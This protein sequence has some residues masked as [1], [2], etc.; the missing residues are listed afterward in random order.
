MPLATSERNISDPVNKMKRIPHNYEM[1]PDKRRLSLAFP[2]LLLSVVLMICG[3]AEIAAQ[4]D[5]G[6]AV[7][8]P[9]NGIDCGTNTSPCVYCSWSP[10]TVNLDTGTSITATASGG[11]LWETYHYA[12]GTGGYNTLTLHEYITMGRIPECPDQQSFANQIT[13]TFSQPVTKVHV[14]VGGEPSFTATDNQGNQV[15]ANLSG[16]TVDLY[17]PNSG[18]S[19][20][21]IVA[22]ITPG[23][24]WSWWIR[25]ASFTPPVVCNCPA[26]PPR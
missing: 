22:N 3:Y 23:N 5:C 14:L 21:T 7:S 1:K 12:T 8:L 4:T 15:T 25:G 16:E 26:I 9:A 24:G 20:V 11:F 13:I 18:I 17:L 2:V 19:T 10:Q 6:R